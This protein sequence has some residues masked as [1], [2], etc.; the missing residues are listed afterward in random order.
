VKKIRRILVAVKDPQA[1]SAP[2]VT[3][4]AQL[5]MEL[6]AELELFHALSDTIVIDTLEARGASAREFE[7][8]E[9]EASRADL[10]KI[11]ARVRRHGVTVHT[12]AEWDHPPHEAIIRRAVATDA[13]LVVVER[14]AGAHRA[15]WLLSYTDW[16]VLRLAPCP[17]LLVKTSKPWHRPVIL[18]AVDPSHAHDKPARLDAQI[19]NL[20]EML[21]EAFKGKLHAVHSFTPPVVLGAG[22]SATPA[23]MPAEVIAGA[24]DEARRRLADQIERMRFR[25]VGQHAPNAPAVIAIPQV[26][27]AQKAALVVMGA[28]SRSGLKR[29]FI[30][31]TAEAVIDRLRSDVLVVKPRDFAAKIPRKVRGMSVMATP[32]P[33]L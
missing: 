30:G 6:E 4:G 20:A 27:E 1:R 11:A 18:A 14:H 24:G 33:M 15:K 8:S 22:L 10:E 7:R 3:R 9:R 13:S 29:V 16:E 23:E 28:V 26:A 17:V 32:T 12:H 5:A 21:R 2:A 19:L 25:G 31:N